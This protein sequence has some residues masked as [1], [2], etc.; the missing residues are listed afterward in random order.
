MDDRMSA[1]E[2]KRRYRAGSGFPNVQEAHELQQREKREAA[3]KE[4]GAKLAESAK[5]GPG[6]P[7]K[8]SYEETA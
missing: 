6:R 1:N 3:M 7:P 2:W 4:A 8:S 5:R